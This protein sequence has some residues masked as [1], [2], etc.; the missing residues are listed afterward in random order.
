MSFMC[1][2]LGSPSAESVREGFA[3]RS[4]EVCG[5]HVIPPA[6]SRGVHLVLVLSAGI[7]VYLTLRDDAN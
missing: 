5:I 3:Q 4:L 2:C 6:E 7:R 1:V